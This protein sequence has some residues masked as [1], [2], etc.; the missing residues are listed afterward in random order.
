MK[1]NRFA[2]E[3]TIGILKEHEAGTPVSELSRKQAV[4]D[5]GIYKMESQV[6][7]HAR[8]RS[9]AAEGAGGWEHEA[10][11]ASGGCHARQCCF[12]R[13]FGK[14]VV[15]PAAKRRA[16]A[17]LM[18]QHWRSERRA[19]KAIGFCRMTIRYETSRALLGASVLGST[20]ETMP[21]WGMAA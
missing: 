16:V 9:P 20:V 11:A 7:R 10:E 6:R 18:N 21:G 1:R 4:S 12:K 8:A 15:T 14:E 2:D 19:C 13:P 17:H 5:A 3:Q